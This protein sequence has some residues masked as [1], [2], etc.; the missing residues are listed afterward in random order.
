MN[1]NRCIKEDDAHM[2]EKI[3]RL[4]FDSVDDYTTYDGRSFAFMVG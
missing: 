2:F 3:Y 1:V 4:G